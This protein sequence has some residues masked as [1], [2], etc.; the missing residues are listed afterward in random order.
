M[1]IYI[2]IY[3]Y[4]GIYVLIHAIRLEELEYGRDNC[5]VD[6]RKVAFISSEAVNSH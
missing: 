6:M 1:L 5:M 2:S 4:E 3:T